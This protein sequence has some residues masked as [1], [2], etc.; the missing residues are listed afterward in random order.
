[1]ITTLKQVP[2]IR[3]VYRTLYYFGVDLRTGRFWGVLLVGLGNLLPDFLACGFVRA[4]LWKLAGARLQDCSSTVIRSGAFVEYPR[5]LVAG[6]NFQVNRGSYF[7]TAGRI[8][9]GDNVTISLAC[10]V[11]T[12]SH[13]GENHEIDVVKDTVLKDHCIIYSGATVLPGTV[14]ERYVVVASGAVIKGATVPGG[15]YAGVP[16]V[17][18]GYRRDVDSSC[19]RGAQD[20]SLAEVSIGVPST[21]AQ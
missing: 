21:T 17:F 19:Y 10:R 3:L 7:D 18:K 16:A 5:N 9:I 6:R 14:I 15:V 1:M 8:T 4:C 12:L 11:L 13:E 2:A 20:G